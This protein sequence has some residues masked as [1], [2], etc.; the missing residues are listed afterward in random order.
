M[1]PKV[2]QSIPDYPRLF[3]HTWTIERRENGTGGE[4][5]IVFQILE[6]FLAV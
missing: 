2:S 6:D 3:Q 5:Y 1:N 4:E